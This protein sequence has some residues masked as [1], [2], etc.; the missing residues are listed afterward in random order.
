MGFF[1][2]SK[3]Q[4]KFF[5]RCESEANL[6]AQLRVA[7]EENDNLRTNLDVANRDILTKVFLGFL[8]KK[9]VLFCEHLLSSF[10]SFVGLSSCFPEQEENNRQLKQLLDRAENER[11]QAV[12]ANEILARYISFWKKE[13]PHHEHSSEISRACAATTKCLEH[14]WQ[15]RK[16]N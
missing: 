13:H 16:M 3:I 15:T 9:Q 6:R 14:G 4:K 7:I 2:L 1:F 11:S 5:C 12:A 8:K 10:M